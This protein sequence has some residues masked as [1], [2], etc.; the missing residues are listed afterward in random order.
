MDG[1][2]TIYTLSLD[3]RA[4]KDGLRLKARTTKDGVAVVSCA[5]SRKVLVTILSFLCP[6][7]VGADET[8][9]HSAR[10]R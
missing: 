7:V 2:A 1:K 8:G 3:M 4:G 6:T 5:V 9:T 10:A